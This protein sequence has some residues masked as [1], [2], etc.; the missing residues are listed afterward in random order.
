MTEGFGGNQGSGW[1]SEFFGSMSMG[2][3]PQPGTGHLQ[4]LDSYSYQAGT[5]STDVTICRLHHH[6]IE[7]AVGDETVQQYNPTDYAYDIV[8]TALLTRLI[9]STCE[10]CLASA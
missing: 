7:P 5:F 2:S 6:S 1:P 10:P 3:A 9:K 8:L 4:M